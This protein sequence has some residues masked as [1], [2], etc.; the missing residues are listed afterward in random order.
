MIKQLSFHGPLSNRQY[1]F[2][3]SSSNADL[4]AVIT[5]FVY[6]ISDKNGDGR[7]LFLNISYAFYKVWYASLLHKL[8]NYGFSCRI[9]DSIQSFLKHRVMKIVLNGFSSKS[10]YMNAVT[11]TADSIFKTTF[12]LIFI[13]N[14]SDLSNFQLGIYANDTTILTVIQIVPIKQN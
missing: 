7:A 14:F 9:Y 12:F 6:Q 10:F 1:G 5:E 2:L 8:K 3:F 13:N 4:I 11:P